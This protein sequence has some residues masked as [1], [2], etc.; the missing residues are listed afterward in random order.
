M[1][2][3]LAPK[4]DNMWSMCI[5]RYVINKIIIKYYFLIPLLDDV[6]SACM[7]FF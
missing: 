4:K 3:L 6:G 1:L 7:C 5:D 2:T